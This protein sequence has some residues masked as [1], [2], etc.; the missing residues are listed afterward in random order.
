MIKG[1]IITIVLSSVST[2]AFADGIKTICGQTD[3]RILSHNPKIGR[4]GMKGEN[5]G[6]SVTMIGKSCAI[7]AGHCAE[8]L[9][10]ASFNTPVSRNY[11]PQRSKTQDIYEV[12]KTSITYQ[13]ET[14]GTD[15]AVLRL[16]KNKITGKYPGDVQGKYFVSFD[17]PRVGTKIRITGYG[18]DEDSPQGNFAQ[19]THTGKILSISNSWTSVTGMSHN[20]DT[21]GGNSGSSILREDNDEIIAIHTNGGCKS[22]GGSNSATLISKH[23]QLKNAIK[24][25]LKFEQD[26]L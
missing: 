25:C 12:F 17:V 2:V 6:C 24:S 22:F 15:W 9:Q 20:I 21:M 23:Q 5:A 16:K 1:L 26:N 13:Y 3:D 14:I 7:T 18:K 10:E 11:T 4:I 8:Y 19:Q